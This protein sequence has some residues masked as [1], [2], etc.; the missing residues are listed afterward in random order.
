MAVLSFHVGE[1]YCYDCVEALKRFLGRVGG[2]RS[3]SVGDDYCA[4]I[5]YDPDLLELNE[6]K[7]KEIVRDNIERLGFRI[8]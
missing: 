4:V 6:E 2:V 3:V 5:D 8:I 1:I 7:F